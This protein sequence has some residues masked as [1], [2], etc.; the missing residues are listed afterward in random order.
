M[1][2]YTFQF[3][4]RR[5]PVVSRGG[6]V[7]ASQPLA[8]AAGLEMLAKGGSAADA[9]KESDKASGKESKA[10]AAVSPASPTSTAKGEA[11]AKGDGKQEPVERKKETAAELRERGP[12][13]SSFRRPGVRGRG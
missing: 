10:A 6:I 9:G 3:D 11:P 12:G 2:E 5:S 1:K 4:S 13:S 7:A 8:V